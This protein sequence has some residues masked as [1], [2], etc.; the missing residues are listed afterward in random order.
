MRCTWYALVAI[1]RSRQYRVL[2]CCVEEAVAGK[3]RSPILSD[4]FI[5]TKRTMF[6]AS[7]HT[8]KSSEWTTRI[9]RV[10]SSVSW[11]L[12]FFHIHPSH[13]N[14]WYSLTYYFMKWCY[15]KKKRKHQKQKKVSTT[16]TYPLCSA[17][18]LFM[19]IPL[20]CQS[21]VFLQYSYRNDNATNSIMFS[22][23]R[24]NECDVTNT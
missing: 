7:L 10:P 21:N 3:W 5:V 19:P 12:V 9:S 15:L 23:H 6:S 17:P 16:T 14:F 4:R 13:L 8:L 24:V 22:K 20:S 1:T 2:W 11:C 18:G